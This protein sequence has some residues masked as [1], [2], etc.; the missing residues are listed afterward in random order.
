MCLFQDGPKYLDV[1]GGNMRGKAGGGGGWGGRNGS[2]DLLAISDLEDMHRR[3]LTPEQ[4]NNL[5]VRKSEKLKLKTL[6]SNEK[7]SKKETTT[8]K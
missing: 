3:F 2:T 4:I 8:E 7:A 6:K 5:T 1:S